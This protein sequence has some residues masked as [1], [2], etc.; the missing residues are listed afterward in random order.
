MDF[1]YEN[2]EVWSRSVDFAVRVVD[3]VESMDTPR[4]HFRLLDQIEASSSSLFR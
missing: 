3:L 1:G 2:L 4:K